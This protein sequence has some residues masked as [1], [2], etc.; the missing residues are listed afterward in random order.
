MRSKI[1]KTLSG[2]GIL[3]A[4]M[5]ILATTLLLL[6][7]IPAQAC[8]YSP[9]AEEVVKGNA[10]ADAFLAAKDVDGLISL[11]TNSNFVVEQRA[12]LHLGQLGAKV[13]VPILEAKDRGYPRF[14]TASLGA[15]RVAITLIEN[16]SVESRRQALLTLAKTGFSGMADLEN[17]RN[18]SI[19]RAERTGSTKAQ[20][21]DLIARLDKLVSEVTKCIK[22]GSVFDTGDSRSDA[23]AEALLEL[24]DEATIRELV[25][26][27]EYGAQYTVLAYRCRKINQAEAIAV[28][29]DVLDRHETPQKAEAAERLLKEYGREAIPSVRDLLRKHEALITAPP[30]PFTIHHTII[31]RCKVIIRTTEAIEAIGGDKGALPETQE[32]VVGAGG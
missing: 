1:F 12:A 5:K 32:K 16:D 7:S 4:L 11:L 9:P 2:P 17:W 21:R 13:A 10:Q 23:A 20:R 18:D 31:S 26:I 29:I 15:F 22:D 28:C 8:L 19:E 27:C 24:G 6:S 3:I 25:P 14:S 30:P